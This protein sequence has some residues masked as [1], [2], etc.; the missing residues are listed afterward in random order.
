MKKVI[1]LMGILAVS[2]VFAV[3]ESRY[4]FNEDLSN[5]AFPEGVWSFEGG[6]LTEDRDDMIFTKDEYENFELSFEFILEKSANSGIMVYVSSDDWVPNSVE[7]QVCGNGSYPDPTW[8]CGGIFGYVAP[9]FYSQVKLGEWQKMK[10][11]C[12]GK[13]SRCF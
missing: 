3:G 8:Q 6:I 10:I 13:K 12:S 7:I 2:S 11:R 1:V 4:L 9:E 5:A